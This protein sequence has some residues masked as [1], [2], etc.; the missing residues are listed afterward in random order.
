MLPGGSSAEAIVWFELVNS[1]GVAQPGYNVL[2]GE[3]IIGA[4]TASI[5]GAAV[6]L[7]LTPTEEITPQLYWRFRVQWYSQQ[8]LRTV[9]SELVE[10]ESVGA[11]LLLPEFLA[12]TP[13]NA[14]SPIW[15]KVTGFTDIAAVSEIPSTEITGTLYIIFPGLTL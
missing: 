10:L 12:L 8:N 11:D 7:P 9:T 3:G 14:A 4:Y 1:S 6:T 5:N 2:T 15:A 13:P